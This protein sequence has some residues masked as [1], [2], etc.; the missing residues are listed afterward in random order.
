MIRP[1]IAYGTAITNEAQYQRFGRAGIERAREPGA[2][3]M[4][5]RGLSLQRAYNEMLDEAA[6]HADLEAVV[7]PHQ[8]MRIEDDAFSATLRTLLADDSIALIGASGG[9]G[10][11]GLA[12]WDGAELAGRFGTATEDDRVVVVGRRPDRPCDVDVIDGTL[13]V[14]SAWAARTL[15]FDL[16]FERDFHGYDSDISFQA[17]AAGKRVVV[18]DL[19]CVHDALGKIGARRGAWVR[20][21]LEFDRKWGAWAGH[22]RGPRSAES[23]WGRIDADVAA[24]IADGGRPGAPPWLAERRAAAR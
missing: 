5:R 13:L 14:F 4:V 1:V 16:R 17:R 19:W 11:T 7:I 3:V 6:G 10:G 9:R 18:A 20:A 15:R 22:G 21:S 8:D 12:W 2:L 24:A 23:V